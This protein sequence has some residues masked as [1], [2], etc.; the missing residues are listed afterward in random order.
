MIWFL[1]VCGT[2][3]LASILTDLFIGKHKFKKMDERT[4]RFVQRFKW[5]GW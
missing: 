2:L 5:N 1:T 4:R 3:F